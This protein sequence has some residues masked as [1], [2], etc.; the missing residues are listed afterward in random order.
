M[1]V[2][3]LAPLALW[4]QI[5]WRPAFRRSVRSIAVG[6]PHLNSCLATSRGGRDHIRPRQEKL[7]VNVARSR[8]PIRRDVITLL[9]RI[10]N[11]NLLDEGIDDCALVRS[12][13]RASMLKK[14]MTIFQFQFGVPEVV[15]LRRSSNV[16][17]R[18]SG[19]CAMSLFVRSVR[20]HCQWR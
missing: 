9:Y 6:L 19:W 16:T 12:L 10:K 4:K 2:A 7:I 13:C 15:S 20:I 5:C 8:C 14:N 1:K 17:F 18:A 11:S 3:V